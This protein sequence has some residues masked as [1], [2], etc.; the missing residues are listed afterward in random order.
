MISLADLSVDLAGRP[1]LRGVHFAAAP[2]E[3]VAICGPNGAGK[4]TLLRAL[5]GLLPGGRAQPRRIAYLEQGARCAWG[6]SVAQVAALGR[7]PHGDQDPAPINRALAACGVAHLAHRPVT[8]ISGGQA[9][10]AMLARALA[11]EAEILLL[12][13]PVADLDPDAAHRIMDL[14]AGQARAGRIVIAVLH[15]VDLAVAYA[16]RMVVL[17]EG[18]IAADGP[19]ADALAV[20]ACCFGMEL[21]IDTAPRLLAPRKEM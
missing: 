16:T 19:P 5:A 15:A 18:R 21:G 6:L 11:T 2:G 3:F 8:A 4:T 12:D 7:I 20:A 13:E 14:L 1:V 10:R 9:R 17:A